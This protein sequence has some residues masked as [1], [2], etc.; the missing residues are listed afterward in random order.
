MQ[1]FGGG[2][3]PLSYELVSLNLMLIGITDPEVELWR[4]GAG[5]ASVPVNFAAHDASS[6]IAALAK[7]G[8]DLC[9]LDGALPEPVKAAALA[10][11]K[12]LKSPP[13]L[14]VRTA[15]GSPR[16]AGMTGVLSRPGNAGEAREM[17]ELCVRT[18]IPTRVL[19]VDDSST[20]RSI[21]RKILLASRFKLDLQEA[22]EGIAALERLRG[23]DFG[24]VF[25]D[26]NMPG[27]NGVETLSE[28]KR[29]T[30]KVAVVMMT[31][32]VDNEIANR[33]HALGALGFLR[34]PF[35]P[36]DIDRVLDRY[37][38]FTAT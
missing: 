15:R 14:F 37:Y 36:A 17:V 10:S 18:K 28:I 26:Y 3:H 34:K 32:T 22:A 31:T 16:P 20:M 13:H 33:A 6:G 1:S 30:P 23:E 29:E 5:L 19:I 9:V 24:L 38:G 21:V 11:I 4:E 2:G 35:Y 25:L 12:A 8:T 27:F 7:G